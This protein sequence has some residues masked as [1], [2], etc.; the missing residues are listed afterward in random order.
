MM[1]RE[2][3]IVQHVAGRAVLD[4]GCVDHLAMMSKTDGWMHSLI[5]RHA[6]DVVGLDNEVEQVT[7]LREQGYNMVCGDAEQVDLHRRF[8]CVVAGELIEHLSNPGQF[9]ANM[10]RHLKPG[11]SIVLTTPNPFYP[12]RLLEILIGGS[13]VVHPQHT[14]WF[15]ARTLSSLLGRAGFER[16]RVQ[17]VN[18]SKAWFGVGTVPSRFRPW[19]STNLVAMGYAPRE[20]A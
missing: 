19:F 18:Y 10:R 14:C 5:R 3:I 6:A 1:T 2:E 8:E 13:A 15:C 4:V 11:G 12:K 9:L 17:H 20:G 16:I 7:L